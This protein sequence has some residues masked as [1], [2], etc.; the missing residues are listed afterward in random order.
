VSLSVIPL[1]KALA[2]M[3]VVTLTETGLEY[4]VDVDEG[5]EPST[6]YLMVASFVLQL[7]ATL[8]DAE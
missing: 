7:S 4:T 5:S 1:L 6:V 3:V 8:R 2:L